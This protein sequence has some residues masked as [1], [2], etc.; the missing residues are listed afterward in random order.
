MKEFDELYNLVKHLRS[1]KGCPWDREQ[2][3]E[4]ISFDLVEEA[5]EINDAII[6]KDNKKLLEE[7]GDLLFLVLMHIII[8][9]EEGSFSIK[10]VIKHVNDKMIYRHPHVFGD[11]N[12]NALDELLQNWEQSK[13]NPFETIPETLPA[14]LMGQKILEK[15]KRIEKPEN[16]EEFLKNKIKELEQNLPSNIIEFLTLIAEFT[17]RGKNAE[18]TLREYLI[19][20]KENLAKKYDSSEPN[21]I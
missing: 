10:D 17:C 21:N 19:Q 6:K 7:L 5:Y 20:I 4:S 15:I 14:L 16:C 12:F 13:Q 9:E 11:R 8:K 3:S 1:D 18:K 2:T